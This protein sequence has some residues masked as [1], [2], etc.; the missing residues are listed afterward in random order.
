MKKIFASLLFLSLSKA[1]QSVP[2]EVIIET[3]RESVEAEHIQESTVGLERL[4]TD[5]ATDN[6]VLFFNGSSWMPAPLTGLNF[7]GGWDPTINTPEILDSTYEDNS[8]QVDAIS[9]DY[10][11][12][13]NSMP[14]ETWNKGDWIVFN[15]SEWERINNTGAVLSIFGRKPIVMPMKGDYRWDQ[16]DK[17]DSSIFDLSNISRPVGD[18][19]NFENHVLKWNEVDEK[20][21]LKEDSKGAE[22]P[23]TSADVLDGTITDADISA[24][25]KIQISKIDG[26][27]GGLGKLKETGGV[28]S[29]LKLDNKNLKAGAAG[30]IIIRD[31]QGVDQEIILSDLKKSF[32]DVVDLYNTKENTADMF[33]SIGG[34]DD[35]LT[36][37]ID[38]V[39]GNRVWSEFNLDIATEGTTNKFQKD[40]NVWS[41]LL[42]GY[43]MANAPTPLAPVNNTDSVIEGLEK[44]EAQLSQGQ[45][46]VL[47]HTP[48]IIDRAVD[49][50]KHFAKGHANS[51][52][53][54]LGGPDPKTW[55][56]EMTS[57]LQFKGEKGTADFPLPTP[58][59][60]GD[61]F[62]ITN[63]ADV[64]G[65]LWNEG[66]WA[67][68]DGQSYLQINNTG[69]VLEFNGRKGVIGTCPEANACPGEYDY[70][71]GM[72][73]MTGS[74]LEDLSDVTAPTA[75][76][77]PQGA[78]VHILKR[79]G[80]GWELKEDKSGVVAGQAVPAA[81][82]G[83]GVIMDVH[84]GN[85]INIDQIENLQTDLDAL[86][87]RTGGDVSGNIDL[88]STNNLLGIKLIDGNDFGK[89]IDYAVNYQDYLDTKEDAL[90]L[91]GDSSSI[92][93]VEPTTSNRV[94][95]KVDSS[96]VPEGQTNFYYTDNRAYAALGAP[97]GAGNYGGQNNDINYAG[98]ANPD[99]IEVSFEKLN[100]KID[101]AGNLPPNSV[102]GDAIAEGT[103]PIEKLAAA[104]NAGETILYKNNDWS[105]SSIS[106][107]QVKDDWDLG[108]QNNLSSNPPDADVIEGEYYI[109][110]GEGEIDGETYRTN[111]WAVYDGSGFNKISNAEYILSFNGR[112]GDIVACPDLVTC[113][114][115]YDY[116]WKDVVMNVDPAKEA[117]SRFDDVDYTLADNA[118]DKKKLL[119]WDDVASKWK[120]V[121]DVEGL[122][123][124]LALGDFSIGAN[125]QKKAVTNDDIQ[126]IAFTDIDG[127]ET[128]FD[129]NFVDLS[130]N[131][132][133]FPSDINF[134][135]AASYNIIGI[136]EIINPLDASNKFTPLALKNACSI[137]DS[138]L[139]ETNFPD[140]N[141]ATVAEPRILSGV[142]KFARLSPE[143]LMG[144]IAGEMYDPDKIRSLPLTGFVEA[145][146]D[147]DL[148]PLDPQ[149][150]GSGTSFLDV[151]NK[152]AG[153][154]KA[155]LSSESAGSE[156]SS[157]G[158]L[159]ASGVLEIDNTKTGKTIFIDD[160]TKLS[161][162][163]SISNDAEFTFKRVDGD[164]VD[165]DLVN[166]EILGDS[167]IKIEG[168]TKIKLATNYSSVT[169]KKIED[170]N[171]NS[172]FVVLRVSG[173]IN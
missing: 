36:G 84:I 28:V 132:V 19:A 59:L 108:G 8:I 166:I 21:E 121:E 41:A 45:G 77:A 32:D 78:V 50:E 3:P 153:K 146:A 113:P 131:P 130:A 65:T 44:L 83:D 111:D 49:Y 71:W 104:N 42:D 66:D 26:Y 39:S 134:N 143:N 119:A 100:D 2:F 135:N 106:G 88:S 91:N 103:I 169:L 85:F 7:R 154:V 139:Y 120:A 107:F 40:E 16:I 6:D 112:V 48:Q 47:V 13:T 155:F 168:K 109:I 10:F 171:G 148:E 151:F 20:F 75:F 141:L 173:T 73:D 96:I 56:V 140:E 123:G 86:L 9:G 58:A 55:G 23:V 67:I 145:T 63:S 142:K 117:L 76:N 158:S 15:G 17:A 53:L 167:G 163:S 22:G 54:L 69:K 11:I 72:L 31:A 118:T 89:V 34:N 170:Q 133:S 38:A 33:N 29:N 25:A 138:S 152:L 46:S 61:Y 57:G 127:L 37:K 115:V 14:D 149:T 24:N 4:T 122:T 60:S 27:T 110:T 18:L 12:V 80:N 87:D 90:N 128:Y 162:L 64:N 105:Y 114:G 5:G 1:V 81:S 161:L 93:I 147:Y 97:A 70:K 92:I 95:K 164:G 43:D 98:S 68:Y 102:T 94:A 52:F 125:G 156:A 82:I 30:K 51:G 172:I 62:V 157:A 129:T 99:S 79:V 74:K 101:N 126:S 136:N 160:T 124:V 35:Y 165:S 150:P 137:L 116:K 159:N 144:D